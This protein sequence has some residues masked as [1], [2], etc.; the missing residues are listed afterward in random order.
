MV[1][2][3]LYKT[4]ISSKPLRIRLEEKDGFIKIYVGI[5]Y[6]VLFRP[7]WDFAIYNR[8]IYL[9]S[10]KSGITDSINHNFA[11]IRIASKTI[12]LS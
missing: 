12:D 7:G 8:V 9:L 4:F 5:R 10:E 11:R 2:Y 3:I 6:L 1:F